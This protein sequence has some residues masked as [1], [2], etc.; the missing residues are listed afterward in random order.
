[1]SIQLIALDLDGTTLQ[2]DHVSISERTERAIRRALARGIHVVPATGRLNSLVPSSIL[3]I[4]GIRYAITSNGAVTYDL[5]AR[6]IMD[7]RFVSPEQ[8]AEVMDLLPENR[9]L[10]ELFKDG[11]M[12][13]Q[14]SYLESLSEY[15]VPFL[16]LDFLRSLHLAVESLRE[17]VRDHGERIEK[18]NLAYVPPEMRDELWDKLSAVR[19]IALTSSVRNNIE[20]NDKRANKGAA[21][22]QLC[23]ILRIPAENVLAMGDGG[24]DLEML[25]FAGVSAVP[26]NG[27][28][29]AKK[30][31]TAVTLSSDQDGVARAIETYALGE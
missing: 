6:E 14:R 31:A 7:S 30:A 18:V 4:D 8:A 10:I 28:E 22:K 19:G 23:A 26:A 24:N 21:L 16:H 11:K 27:I 12:V 1:M 5:A 15:P 3:G 17:Y 25:R 2:N 9:I 29:E 20:I 13:A